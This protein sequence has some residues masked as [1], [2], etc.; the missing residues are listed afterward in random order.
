MTGPL[1]IAAGE[2]FFYSH[3]YWGT[4][5]AGAFPET[6]RADDTDSLSSFTPGPDGRL[7]SLHTPVTRNPVA[8]EPR[9]PVPPAVMPGFSSRTAQTG[10]HLWVG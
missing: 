1:F 4:V 6:T 5:I 7:P 2:Q 9:F 3:P 10:S 8:R